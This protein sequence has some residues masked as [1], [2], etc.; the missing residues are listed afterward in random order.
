MENTNVKRIL[1]S[2]SSKNVDRSLY[3]V[4]VN[5]DCR[6]KSQ[7]ITFRDLKLIEENH[8]KYD[9]FETIFALSYR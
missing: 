2:D 6:L 5:V 3:S 1:R 7:Q 9:E 8:V 4:V